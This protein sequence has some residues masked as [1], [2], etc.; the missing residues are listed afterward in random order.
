M[1]IIIY[2]LIIFALHITCK[3][4]EVV[5][6][7]SKDINSDLKSRRIRLTEGRLNSALF[8]LVIHKTSDVNEFRI[9]DVC[10]K[11]NIKSLGFHN[12]NFD[13]TLFSGIHECDWSS[14]ES[15]QISSSKVD[16]NL[17][18]S[19]F[20]YSTSKEKSLSLEERFINHHIIDC[21]SEDTG[22]TGL[23]LYNLPACSDCSICKILPYFST[24][25]S[26]SILKSSE[27]K[28]GLGCILEMPNLRSISL[29][30]WKGATIKEFHEFAEKYE[31]KYN[32]KIEANI[33]DPVGYEK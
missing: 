28:V 32:R 13:Q 21:K 23:S 4:Q 1:R 17:L 29:Q 27:G 14:L 2:L 7:N 11:K 19:L 6:A 25:T 5:V 8:T 24:I 16:L 3:N 26:L 10:L 18:C 15:L 30:S 33:I 12:D 22:I 9:T 20:K 31:K